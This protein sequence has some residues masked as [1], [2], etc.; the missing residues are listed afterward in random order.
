VPTMMPTVSHQKSEGPPDNAK[1]AFL[2]Y[3]FDQQ[4]RESMQ[5]WRQVTSPLPLCGAQTHAHRLCMSDIT[6]GPTVL[7]VRRRKR[8]GPRALQARLQPLQ[9]PRALAAVPG[10]RPLAKPFHPVPRRG[11]AAE[12]VSRE[13]FSPDRWECRPAQH[14]PDECARTRSHSHT[15]RGV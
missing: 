6:C 5:A 1:S 4:N 15:R 10:A 13:E 12:L 11:A 8:G 9:R 7:A 2:I 14:T 3:T